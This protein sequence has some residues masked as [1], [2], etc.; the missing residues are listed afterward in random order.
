M[1]VITITDCPPKLRGDITKWLC[2]INTGVYVGNISARVREALWDRICAN[3]SGGRAT[4]V[5]SAANEQRLEFRTNNSSLK[6][7]DFD[8]IKLMMH[9]A[10]QSSEEKLPEGFSKASKYLMYG[11]RKRNVNMDDNWVFVDIESTGL[12]HERDS[13]IEIAA[14]EANR[15]GIASKWSRII[16]IDVKIPRP[17]AELTQITDEMIEKG[18]SLSDALQ[19]L[20]E[21]VDGKTVICYNKSFDIGFLERAFRD[22]QMAFP[23]SRAIDA[24]TLARQTIRDVKNYK[25]QTLAEYFDVPFRNSH[26]ALDDCEMLYMVYLKLNEN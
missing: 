23:I 25:L 10:K 12:N 5:Y 7:R 19:E 11:R 16:K 8:G 1:I 4:M 24:L 21:I 13:I 14:I 15:N 18:I 26:R 9:P 6:I 2:E 3:I 20:A 17:I 22:C